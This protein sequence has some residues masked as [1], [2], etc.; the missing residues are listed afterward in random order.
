MLRLIKK[1]ASETDNT[2]GSRRM[3]K[4][5]NIL[6]FPISR[7]KARNL[8]R[9]A[10]VQARHRKKYK[11]TTNSDHQQPVFDNLIQRQFDVKETDRGYV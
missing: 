3:K 4:A 1:I 6:G 5:M 11:V 2:Y 7:S 9:E 8:M 10:D